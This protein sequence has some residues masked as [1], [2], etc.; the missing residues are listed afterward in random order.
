[1]SAAAGTD[2]VTSGYPA[3]D[4]RYVAEELIPAFYKRHYFY[5][6][7]SIAQIR[8][9][10]SL[11]FN[12]PN[13]NTNNTSVFDPT[14]FLLMGIQSFPPNANTFAI[15]ISKGF[16]FVN[17]YIGTGQAQ[18]RYNN[19]IAFPG[20]GSFLEANTQI[21]ESGKAYDIVEP[22]N[23]KKFFNCLN[24][25]AGFPKIASPMYLNDS[26]TTD[27]STITY[28]VY[29]Y[30]PAQFL[31]TSDSQHVFQGTLW[32]WTGTSVFSQNII[33]FSENSWYYQP[34]DDT[35]NYTYGK[36]MFVLKIDKNKFNSAFK[37]FQ[38]WKTGQKNTFRPPGTRDATRDDLEYSF[39]KG[40]NRPEMIWFA[41]TGNYS[42]NVVSDK[43]KE[44]YYG[45]NYYS[46]PSQAPSCSIPYSRGQYSGATLTQTRDDF[47]DNSNPASPPMITYESCGQSYSPTDSVVYFAYWGTKPD[48]ATWA[49]TLLTPEALALYPASIDI[50]PFSSDTSNFFARM[51]TGTNE[52]WSM[53]S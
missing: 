42:A 51:F 35:T 9:A 48:Q 19:P 34:L 47:V 5:D 1:M 40:Y 22:P 53:Y 32:N 2:I 12:P 37:D 3:P 23:T 17:V 28:P 24:D 30:K 25:G 18:D 15:P 41:N 8:Q 16:G 33:P 4:R 29:G 14:N 39:S 10:C 52:K 21:I 11:G 20:F 49:Q 38:V 36:E 50:L 44:G 43:S 27:A 13:T 46:Y 7:A 26:K 45:I 6:I 31:D